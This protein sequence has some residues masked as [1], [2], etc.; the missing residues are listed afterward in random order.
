MLEE[1]RTVVSRSEANPQ[2]S[3]AAGPELDRARVLLT[4]A[5]AIWRDKRDEPATTHLAYLAKQQA[6]IAEARGQ[7]HAADTEITTA[8]AERDRIR[9]EARTR[10]A[11][12]VRQQANAQIAE[13]QRQA[14]A[15]QDMAAAASEEASAQAERAAKLEQELQ[16]LDARQTSRGMV[17]TMQDVVFDTGK[18]DLKPGAERVIERLTAL[19]KDNPERK[20]LVEGFTDNVGSDEYNRG[21]SE[22]RANAVRNALVD[23]GV[24]PDRVEMRGYGESFPVASNDDAAG[25]QLN[26]RVEVVISDEHGMLPSRD[27]LSSVQGDTARRAMNKGM[28]GA[29]RS[30]S[31]SAVPQGM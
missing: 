8:T 2:V 25:R 4:R 19:L 1:A 30:R 29:A 23:R 6:S 9:L 21:L 15:A 22:R 7:Q 27:S 16:E 18:A 14:A 3:Q 20:V 28:A 17:V 11:A 31:P 13:S 26:R 5:D 12:T 10:E 24:S